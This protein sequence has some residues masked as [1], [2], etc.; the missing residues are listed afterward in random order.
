ML[1]TTSFRLYFKSKRNINWFVRSISIYLNK[2]IVNNYSLGTPDLSIL[3][4]KLK[5]IGIAASFTV[6]LLFALLLAPPIFGFGLKIV[7]LYKECVIRRIR[8]AKM[9]GYNCAQ[10]SVIKLPYI[11]SLNCWKYI[12]CILTCSCVYQGD[13]LMCSYI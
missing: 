4:V 11:I 9:I 10:N 13:S 6:V 8:D 5:A 1:Y 3:S 7:Y 2:F 12:Y